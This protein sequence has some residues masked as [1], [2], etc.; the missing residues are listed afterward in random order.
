MSRPMPDGSIWTVGHST[1]SINAFIDL[2]AAHGIDRLADVRTLPRS[3]R[4][5]QFSIDA[6]SRSLAAA[7]IEYRHFPALGGLRKP[8]GDPANTP[9]RHEGFRGYAEYMA[10]HE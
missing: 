8:K 7:G 3:R 10:T 1:L 9:W 4:H 5:P 6:L 2:L